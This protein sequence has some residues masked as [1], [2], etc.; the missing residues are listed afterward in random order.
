MISTLNTWPRSLPSPCHFHDTH[1]HPR[2]FSS[3]AHYQLLHP[4]YW[5]L[6]SGR[7]S[8]IGD[9]VAYTVQHLPPTAVRNRNKLT[10]Q[11]PRGNFPTSSCAHGRTHLARLSRHFIF[12]IEE[13]VAQVGDQGGILR[14][15][16]AVALVTCRQPQESTHIH[17]PRNMLSSSYHVK[18]LILYRRHV[19][20]RGRA[21]LPPR[22]RATCMLAR[23]FACRCLGQR[24][25][26]RC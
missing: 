13:A 12:A 14:R 6:L 25:P 11:S 17:H 23:E 21:H 3:A 1:Q 5:C 20:V 10:A 26:P 4:F 8:V 7:P 19:A 9:E 16:S 15:L 24:A 22:P 2:T 18:H